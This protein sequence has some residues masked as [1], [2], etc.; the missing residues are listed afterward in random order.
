ML[1]SIKT[2]LHRTRERAAARRAYRLLEG[3]SD[4]LLRDMGLTRD[5]MFRSVV[6]GQDV[7]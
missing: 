4:H 6:H 2:A 1:S 7:R 3:Q 5:G